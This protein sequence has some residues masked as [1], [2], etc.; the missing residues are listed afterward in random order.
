[1]TLKPIIQH[2]WYKW[3]IGSDEFTG[4]V[5]DAENMTIIESLRSISLSKKTRTVEKNKRAGSEIIALS[6]INIDW[7]RSLY[8]DDNF[9]LTNDWGIESD[10]YWEL[11]IN[12]LRRLYV[13]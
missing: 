6:N 2:E 9:Y 5:F 3:W 4:S 12:I 8:S 11:S 1:M 7:D 10:T 13:L